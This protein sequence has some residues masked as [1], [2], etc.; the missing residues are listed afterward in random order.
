M[1]RLA[2]GVAEGRDRF[3][4]GD[5]V[6]QH[7]A[8]RAELADLELVVAHRLDLGGVAGGD[9]E[10]HRAAE[11]VADQLGEIGVDRQHPLRQ[12]VGLDAKADPVRRAIGGARGASRKERASGDGEIQRIAHHVQTPNLVRSVPANSTV[13]V[14]ARDGLF[15]SACR[16]ARGGG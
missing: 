12:L 11:L 1:R 7:I 6:G 16:T 2:F 10:L 13:I 3:R 4:L 14:A 5:L 15:T 9:E 8:E